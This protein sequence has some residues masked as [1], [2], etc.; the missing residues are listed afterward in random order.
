MTEPRKFSGR[1][2]IS[3]NMMISFLVLVVSSVVLYIMPSGR[4]SYWTNWK[5]WGLAKDQWGAL[6][7]VG[8]LAFVVFGVFHLFIYNWKVFWNYV[9]SKL[10]KHLNKKAE[11]AGAILLNILIVLVC[12]FS[13]FPSSMIMNWG[14]S[15]KDS[16]VKPGQRAPYGHAE[17]DKIDVLSKRLG[18]DLQAVVKSLE[19]KGIKV[20]VQKTVKDIASEN[21]LTP[22]QLFEMMAPP[23]AQGAGGSGSVKPGLQE[24][25]GWGRKTVKTLAEEI[26]INVEAA[27]A[28][29]NVKGIQAKPSSNLRE[30]AGKAGLTPIE[31]ADIV[32]K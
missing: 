8:G 16:W 24:G 21:G 10:R 12:V 25:G 17:I 29:L 4:D 27:L 5:L 9:I 14:A 19:D 22:G 26:G 1:A 11:M 13:W 20:D 3:I 28:K 30:L 32:R 6:H 2:F 15:L 18:L 31:I 23:A 7:T